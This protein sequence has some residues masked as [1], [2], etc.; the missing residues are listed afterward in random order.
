MAAALASVKDPHSN[1]QSQNR[2]QRSKFNIEKQQQFSSMDDQNN[3]KIMQA[4]SV[5]QKYM[6]ELITK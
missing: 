6:T 5:N 4:R 3:L 2:D 1:N